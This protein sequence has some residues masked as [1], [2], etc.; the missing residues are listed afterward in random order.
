MGVGDQYSLVKYASIQDPAPDQ[1]IQR[2]QPR[3]PA[4]KPLLNLANSSLAGIP[5]LLPAQYVRVRRN[6]ALW[7]MRSSAI[8]FWDVLGL[9]P[10]NGPK[11]AAAYVLY[12]DR[13]NL[14]GIS[15]QLMKEIGQCYENCKLGKHIY[16]IPAP[17]MSLK[18][19]SFRGENGEISSS[20]HMQCVKVG[21]RLAMMDYD[22]SKSNSSRD[23]K[24]VIIVDARVIYVINPCEDA[25]ILHNIAYGFLALKDAYRRTKTPVSYRKPD[26]VLQIIP[27]SSIHNVGEVVLLDS[28]TAHMLAREVYNRC[29]PV[30]PN[31]DA[32]ALAISSGSSI[33]LMETIPRKIAFELSADPPSNIMQDPSHL[34]LGY[35]ISQSGNWVTAA[36]SDNSGKY[37]AVVSYCLT[38]S[39]TFSDIAKEIWQ[40]SIDIMKPRRVNWRLYILKVGI[41]TTDEMESWA[42][43]ALTPQPFALVTLLSSMDFSPPL[44]LL[45]Q[46]TLP[47][48]PP[49]WTFRTSAP[50]PIGTPNTQPGVSPDPSAQTPAAGTPSENTTIADAASNDPDAHLVDMTDETWT[51]I[52]GHR[53]TLPTPSATSHTDFLQALSSALLIRVPPTAPASNPFNPAEILDPFQAPCVALHLLWAR[54]SAKSSV[55][56]SV[57]PDTPP[58]TPS[59]ASATGNPSAVPKAASDNIMRESLAYLRNLA[60]LA[61]VRGVKDG[62]AGLIPW[63]AL[64]AARG[65][66]GLDGVYGLERWAPLEGK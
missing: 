42:S 11:S 55:V 6:D 46:I 37:Q 13:L 24:P 44:S 38:G 47:T 7:D 51:I 66:D 30:S 29:P 18:F 41:M 54:N 3:P 64:I 61:K 19:N 62:K 28:A 20:Y 12:P 40:T 21:G 39:R 49:A 59:G 27:L 52:L 5:I 32:G 1:A 45:P 26:V 35:A 50:T 14:D 53:V 43:L 8:A 33:Q 22:R 25:S 9:A 2:P 4:P 15:S 36:Y 23:K 48:S 60:L 17:D 65:V 34:H 56:S 16:D 58:T 57:G 10:T 31:E 63:H